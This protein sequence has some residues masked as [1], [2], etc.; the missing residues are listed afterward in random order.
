VSVSSR[1][2]VKSFSFAFLCENAKKNSTAKSGDGEV[3]LLADWSSRFFSHLVKA[4]FCGNYAA[5][6]KGLLGT[7]D[8]NNMTPE[9]LKAEIARFQTENDALKAK[10][11]ARQHFTLKVSPKGAVSIYGLGRFPVT[12]Y[13]GQ[14]D[15]LLA[16]SDDIKAFIAAN[17]A[18][19]K[20]KE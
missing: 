7:M 2:E 8:I 18:T 10:A 5:F 15:T 11:A 17:V 3:C 16:H 4:V 14:M 12:L 9:Q 6:V 19:L 20:V 1:L 13:K